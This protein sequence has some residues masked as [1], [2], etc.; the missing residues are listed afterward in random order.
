M[1]QFGY[2]DPS[3][4]FHNAEVESYATQHIAILYGIH[5][6]KWKGNNK[7]KKVSRNTFHYKFKHYIFYIHLYDSKIKMKEVRRRSWEK[8][9]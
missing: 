2:R 9:K 7:R 5:N 3:L 1:N 8:T 6:V 4:I